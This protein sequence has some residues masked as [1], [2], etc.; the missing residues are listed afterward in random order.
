MWDYDCGL[1]ATVFS[2]AHHMFQFGV[3]EGKASESCLIHGVYEVLVSVGEARLLAQELSVKVA[4]VTWGF[5][6]V[7]GFQLTQK[8]T[9]KVI[10]VCQKINHRFIPLWA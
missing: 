2:F 5:L 8:S 3:D 1:W 7:A 4:A 10:G 9:L 6:W